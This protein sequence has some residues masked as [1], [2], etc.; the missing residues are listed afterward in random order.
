MFGT[1]FVVLIVSTLALK[2]GKAKPAPKKKPDVINNKQ[3]APKKQ[4]ISEE[5]GL[6]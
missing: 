4:V 1:A 6:K 5:S 3:V 2:P